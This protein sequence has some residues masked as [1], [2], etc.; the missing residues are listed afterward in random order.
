MSHSFNSNH[1]C[2]ETQYFFTRTFNKKKN[3]TADSYFRKRLQRYAGPAFSFVLAK[4]QT[5]KQI[6]QQKIESLHRV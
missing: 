6:I 5:E 3:E 4:T 2:E 1:Y